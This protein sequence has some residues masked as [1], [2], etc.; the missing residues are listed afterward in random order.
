MQAGKLDRRITIEDL[1]RTSDGAGGWTETWVTLATVWAEKRKQSGDEA[2]RAG[3]VVPA[4]TIVFRTQYLSGVTPEARVKYDS[5]TYDITSVREIG[6]RE[7]LEL[8]TEWVRG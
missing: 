8:T 4:E 7:G 2:F 5:E 6:R 3:G 1:Q